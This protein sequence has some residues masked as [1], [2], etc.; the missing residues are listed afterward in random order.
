[1]FFIFIIADE[2]MKILDT[3]MM[4]IILSVINNKSIHLSNSSIDT[5]TG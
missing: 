3:D 1:M 4:W 2:S 5:L